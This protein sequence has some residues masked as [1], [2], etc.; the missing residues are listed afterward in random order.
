MRRKAVCITLDP[1]DLKEV[2]RLA[3]KEDRSVSYTINMFIKEALQKPGLAKRIV[4]RAPHG[5]YA[6]R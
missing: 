2:K 6:Q 4:Q 3:Q 1:N 5:R